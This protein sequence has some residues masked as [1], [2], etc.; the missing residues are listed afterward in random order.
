MKIEIDSLELFAIFKKAGLDDRD[1]KAL[2]FDILA[3][4][5]KKR[6]P[7]VPQHN[8]GADSPRIRI[9][10]P[11]QA[12][13]PEV[14]PVVKMTQPRR[15]EEAQLEDYGDDDEEEENEMAPVTRVSGKLSN[16]DFSAFGGD[17]TSF[18]RK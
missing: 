3:I 2:I 9:N 8:G 14:T 10:K 6:N 17:S 15:Q 12:P 7:D 13:T 5:E 18:G 4:Q 16:K 1:S 11:M